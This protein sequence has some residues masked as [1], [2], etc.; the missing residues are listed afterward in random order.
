MIMSRT[1]IKIIIG[2]PIGILAWVVSAGTALIIFTWGLEQFALAVVAAKFVSW[3]MWGI[4]II[5][6]LSSTDSLKEQCY[7]SGQVKKWPFLSSSIS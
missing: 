4:S 6:Q 3:G 1:S 2:G 5:R 7:K